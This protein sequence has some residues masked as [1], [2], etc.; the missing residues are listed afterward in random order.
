MVAVQVTKEIQLP[1]EKA[2]SLLDDFGGI[3]NFHPLV[4]ESGIV[5]ER[6]T[7]EGAERFCDFGKGNRIRERITDYAS[8]ERMTIAIT[9]TSKFPLKEAVATLS[10]EP[11]GDDRSAVTFDFDFEPKFGPGP[12]GW[13]LGNTVMAA[14]FRRVLESVIDGLERYG[15]DV[16]A[17]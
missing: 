7:G 13:I 11:R 15:R 17:A 12:L 4:R 1:A 10:V 16:K 2:W 14:Q 3:Q 5:G 9:D 8:G 6:P